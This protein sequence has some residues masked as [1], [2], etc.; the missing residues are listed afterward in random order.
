MAINYMTKEGYDALVKEIEHLEKLKDP[1]LAGRLPKLV[2]RVTYR[3][4]PNMTQPKKPRDDGNENCQTK[5]DF[6]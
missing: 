5:N 1:E 3:K 2:K 4:M 6:G